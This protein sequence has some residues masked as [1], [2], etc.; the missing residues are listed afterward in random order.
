MKKIKLL[1]LAFLFCTFNSAFAWEIDYFQVELWSDSAKTWEAL[2]LTISAMDKDNNIVDDYLGQI[3]IF[4][5]TDPKAEL[6]SVL[7]EWSY[8]Y[9]LSDAWV[10]KFENAVVFNSEWKHDLHVYDLNDETDSI[11]WITEI[12]IQSWSVE[13]P[14]SVDIVITAPEPF[15]TLTTSDL[16]VVGSTVGNYRVIVSANGTEYET[17]SNDDGIFELVVP[18]QA[19]GDIT[20]EA[21]VVDADNEVIGEATGVD[22]KLSASEPVILWITTTPEQWVPNFWYRI[23]IISE[24]WLQT[25][26]LE[27]NDSI[28]LLTETDPWTY[29]WDFIAP[30][31]L[32]QYAISMVLQNTLWVKS[33]FLN[34]ASITVIAPEPEAEP[35]LE[36]AVE[37]EIEEEAIEEEVVEEEAEIVP[38]ELPDLKITWLKLTELKTKS[39]LDWDK[40]E[41]ADSYNVYMKE[42][43]DLLFVEKVTEPRVTVYITGDEITYNDFVVRAVKERYQNNENLEWDLSDAVKIQ[44]GPEKYLLLFILT[45][46]MTV[47]ITNRKRIFS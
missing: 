9:T 26:E 14:Q 12:D 3:L 8:T 5:Q 27:I 1:L 46:L 41:D 30:T 19:D 18:G 25:V 17:I 10:V 6:P 47:L 39:V 11:V 40:L 33:T 35:E 28:S 13:V 42:W 23:E 45:F 16:Q 24:P 34:T 29:V 31:E 20:I 15:T 7:D 38:E 22:V 37:E 2:D 4:S 43:W 21:K 32:W 36:S 44:T